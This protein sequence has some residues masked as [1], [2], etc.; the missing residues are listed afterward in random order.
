MKF[1][2][3]FIS[4]VIM[5]QIGVYDMLANEGNTLLPSDGEV[6]IAEVG[7]VMPIGNI[8][9]ARKS[10]QYCA[11]K[12]TKYWEDNTSE[13]G[14][15]FVASGSDKYATYEAFYQWDKTGDFSKKNVQFIEGKLSF[16]KPRGIG[17]FVFSF[18]DREVNCGFIKLG[19]VW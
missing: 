6:F 7:I 17:R 9:L 2:N 3:V 5:L 19:M 14:T 15:L 10:S 16:P 13:V 11:L 1:L 18:S 4:S 8:L 12:F